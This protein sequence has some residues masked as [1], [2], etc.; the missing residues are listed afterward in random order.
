[1]PERSEST[2]RAAIEMPPAVRAALVRGIG[3]F[4]QATPAPEL[5]TSVR[6]FRTFKPSALARHEKALLALLDDAATRARILAWMDE[7]KPRLAK[8]VR[9]ALRV[10]AERGTAW[11]ELADP[12]GEAKVAE[13]PAARLEELERSLAREKEK[14][15]KAR[16]EARK[17]RSH[18]ADE[19]SAARREQAEAVDRAEAMEER[20]DGAERRAAAAEDEARKERERSARASRRARR[21]LERAREE[22]DSL[23]RQV[24][25]LKRQVAKLRRE[26]T[27]AEKGRS[28]ADARRRKPSPPEPSGPREPLP[29]P[30]GRFE[31]APETLDAWL[32]VHGVHL[33]V[34]GY[35]VTLAE[36]GFGD[37]SLEQQRDRLITEV[38][39]LIRRKKASATIVFDGSKVP[40]GIARLPRGPAKVEFSK[41]A[42]T[43]DDHIIA[44]IEGLPPFPV[45][46]ATD[47]RELQ[48]R[49]RSMGATIA[50]SDQLLALIR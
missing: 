12:N 36:R 41:P 5:P 43:A 14:V 10:A 19:V 50:T 29:V 3:A 17:G 18:A 46:L 6:R 16:D 24:K 4:L 39:K 27:P 2:P 1:M 31:D 7:D 32:E 37:V 25:D 23:A 45:I 15:R 44:S 34:D 11:D 38:T 30:P 33:V 48:D 22:R 13:D 40:A 42:E 8:E 35:N 9:S 47:D 21:D 28:R 20:L 49:A 26:Q